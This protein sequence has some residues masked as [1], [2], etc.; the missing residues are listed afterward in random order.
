MRWHR[1]LRGLSW[2][3]SNFKE[4]FLAHAN[5]HGIWKGIFDTFF[6]GTGKNDGIFVT[7]GIGDSVDRIFSSSQ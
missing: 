1:C 2:M 7:T 6:K 5:M 4:A 3:S